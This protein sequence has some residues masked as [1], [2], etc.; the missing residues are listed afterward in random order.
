MMTPEIQEWIAVVRGRFPFSAGRVLEIG[1]QN[2]NGTVRQFFSDA[3]EYIGTDMQ[4]GDGVDVVLDNKSLMTHFGPNSFDTIVAC[5]V[6]EHD[7]IFWQ[8]IYQIRT[9]LR[10]GGHVI[11]TTP[12]LGFPYH[13]YPKDYWRFTEDAYRDFFFFGMEVLDIST[14][15]N[16]YAPQISLAGLAKKG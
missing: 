12:T 1:S 14:L 3:S 16:Q 6:L 15:D 4:Q 10:V 9:L 11:I 13:P 5:E 2:I 8:T 7:R